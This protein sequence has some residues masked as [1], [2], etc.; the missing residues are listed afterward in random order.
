MMFLRSQARRG[1][2]F[3]QIAVLLLFAGATHTVAAADEAEVEDASSGRITTR[4]TAEGQVIAQVKVAA[5]PAA[6]REILASAEQAH[7]LASTTVSVKA[8]RDGACEKVALQTR[9]LLSPFS[10]ETRRC[11][12]S[13]GWKETMVASQDFVEYWNEWVVQEQD[14]GALIS[15]KTRTLPNVS[16][17]ESLI[18]SQ[19]RR[20]LTRLMRNLLTK[21]GEG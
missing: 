14:G 11:P 7:G 17:P 19:T 3:V 15:F 21:L 2:T 6:V 9:G 16:V 1:R 13:T 5:K 10:L 4:V 20:V 12:T 18:L 8:T